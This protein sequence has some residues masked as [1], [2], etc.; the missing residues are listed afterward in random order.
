MRWSYNLERSQSAALWLFVVALL[1]VA[2]VLVGGATRVT[3]SGLSIVE[4]RPVTGALPP[5]SEQGWLAEFAKYQAIPQYKL[6]NQGMT[7][8]AFKGIYW[9]EWS[10]RLLGRLIGFVFL[11]PFVILLLRKRIPRR[12]IWRCWMIF[13]LGGLQGLVGW[14]MVA[15]GLADRVSV[16]PERLA[17]HLGLAL[18]IFIACIWTGLEAWFGRPRGPFD[19][20]PRWRLAGFVTMGLVFLQSLLGALVAGSKAGMVNT[21]WPLMNG[22]F[23]PRDYWIEGEGILQTMLH[24]QAAVQFNHRV[25]AYLIFVA[26]AAL[27]GAAARSDRLSHAGRSLT[28]AL[29]IAVLVQIGLGIVTLLAAAPVGLSLLHQIG[30][31]VALTVATALTWRAA[32]N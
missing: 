16:A 31:V 27:V 28:Y 7:L 9:W 30:A 23:V 20:A 19:P 24:N 10:H 15:S 4:W 14:W 29:G 2:M 5:L 22:V 25:V 13:A 26:V 11:V 21:D 3:G 8:A 1:V 12:L 32:R 18:L 6:V 17:T